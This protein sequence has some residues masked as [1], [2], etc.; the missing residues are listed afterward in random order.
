MRMLDMNLVQ[1]RFRRIVGSPNTGNFGSITDKS[2][3]GRPAFS[4]ISYSKVKCF[5]ESAYFHV[6]KP[7]F[8]SFSEFLNKSSFMLNT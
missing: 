5:L 4:V 1:R 6:K 7:F 2:E 3:V 8:S